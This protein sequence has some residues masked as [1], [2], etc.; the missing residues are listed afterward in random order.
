MDI[1]VYEIAAGLEAPLTAAVVADLHSSPHGALIDALKKISPDLIL[2]P[3][4]ILHK[5]DPNEAGLDFLREASGLCPTFCSM[6]NHE[7]KHGGDVREHI[8]ATGAIL[9]DDEFA[10][11]EGITIGGL[12]TG[13][14]TATKQSRLKPAPRP[15]LEKLDGF[16][17]RDG[18]KILLSHHPE[19]YES[20]L[21]DKSASLIISGHAHGGQWRVFGQG[22]FAPGQGIFPKYT[23]GMYDGR[24]LVSR[25]LSN[26]TKIPRIFNSTELIILK[27]K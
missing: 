11:F 14:T 10:D 22:I 12:S 1:N 25:G 9:L 5:A 13:Y 7:V 8:R 23:S 19:Y 21:K 15:R 18:F 2:C 4:D 16:F 17:A 24:L 6:G 26:Q 20:Y 27:L 3:G